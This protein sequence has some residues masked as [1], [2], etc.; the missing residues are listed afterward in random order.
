MRHALSERRRTTN[1][2]A[3]VTSRLEAVASAAISV[4]SAHFNPRNG[5]VGCSI[6]QLCRRL[7]CEGDALPLLK[8]AG[9][10]RADALRRERILVLILMHIAH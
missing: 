6:W 3:S 4:A 2:F 8:A 1:P 5:P 7:G 9:I 10:T